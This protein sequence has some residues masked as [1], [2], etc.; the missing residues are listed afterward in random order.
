MNKTIVIISSLKELNRTVISQLDDVLVVSQNT[1]IYD[2]L[3]SENINTMK[4]IEYINLSDDNVIDVENVYVDCE[5]I[6][7][8]MDLINDIKDEYIHG[9]NLVLL[10][11]DGSN[12]NDGVNYI[13]MY[14]GVLYKNEIPNFKNGMTL[15]IMHYINSI[16]LNNKYNLYPLPNI[17]YGYSSVSIRDCNDI[18]IPIFDL[19]FFKNIVKNIHNIIN[20]TRLMQNKFITGLLELYWEEFHNLNNVIIKYQ[21]TDDF[22]SYIKSKQTISTHVDIFDFLSE[23][24]PDM[25]YDDKDMI[26]DFY[27]GFME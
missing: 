5:Y 11:Y 22:P 8:N 25:E 27:L 16:V 4:W 6:Y 23:S 17:N 7:D 9:Y 24:F 15:H 2:I 18:T 26:E 19:E 13:N 14:D 3:I 21:Y 10:C 1:D 12:D 20:D